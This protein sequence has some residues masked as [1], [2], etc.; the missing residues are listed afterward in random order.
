MQ[1]WA[2]SWALG[3]NLKAI[4]QL[5]SADTLHFLFLKSSF[6]YFLFYLVGNLPTPSQV[7]PPSFK[8]LD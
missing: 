5:L 6:L 8:E 3:K 1:G 2:Y 7:S 4:R